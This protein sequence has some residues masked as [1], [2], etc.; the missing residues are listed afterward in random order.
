[1]AKLA[2]RGGGKMSGGKKWSWRESNP[3]PDAFL[4]H[5]KHPLCHEATTLY[6]WSDH[7]GDLHGLCHSFVCNQDSN[8]Q[9]LRLC[10]V[11]GQVSHHTDHLTLGFYTFAHTALDYCTTALMQSIYAGCAMNRMACC[12]KCDALWHLGVDLQ[13]HTS[14]NSPR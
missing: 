14:T 13:F 4:H 11:T 8:H 6:D 5:A 12:E 10:S 2:K 9:S 7:T 3:R 1:M